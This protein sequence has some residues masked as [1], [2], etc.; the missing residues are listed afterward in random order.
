[1]EAE[2]GGTRLAPQFAIRPREH[3]IVAPVLIRESRLHS[4]RMVIAHAIWFVVSLPF[5]L[6]YWIAWQARRAGLAIATASQRTIGQRNTMLAFAV[7]MAL[8]GR[9]LV[10]GFVD[11]SPRRR[12]D[13]CLDG[14]EIPQGLAFEAFA[15]LVAFFA[16]RRV[17]HDRRPTLSADSDPVR[18]RSEDWRLSWG[19]VAQVLFFVGLSYLL[20]VYLGV[21]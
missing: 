3:D 1:M 19:A 7:V 12:F 21:L 14:L 13:G 17:P 10:S 5:R 18:Y 4:G 2:F 11:C 6:L 9:G 20:L 15:A 16:V 8:F